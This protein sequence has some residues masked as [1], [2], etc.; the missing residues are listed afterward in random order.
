MADNA[1]EKLFEE[2][3]DVEVELA[4]A[5]NEG[6]E[7][8]H[9][10]YNLRIKEA[11]LASRAKLLDATLRK[12]IYDGVPIVQAKMIAHEEHAEREAN[13]LVAGQITAAQINVGSISAVNLSSH[14]L[15]A[16]GSAILKNGI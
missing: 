5:K 11:K 6:I 7:L 1:I 9:G 2:M 16:V 15:A 4:A 12:H 3:R 8:N 13:P 10:L 14:N